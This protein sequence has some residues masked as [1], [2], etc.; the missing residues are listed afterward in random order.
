MAEPTEVA[1]HTS[2]PFVLSLCSRFCD[3]E[4]GARAAC[5]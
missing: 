3:S 2:F 5:Q 4:R 1:P